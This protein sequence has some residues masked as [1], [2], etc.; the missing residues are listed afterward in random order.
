MIHKSDVY[1]F[2]VVMILCPSTQIDCV[3]KV[4]MSML[5]CCLINSFY[6]FEQQK[7]RILCRAKNDFFDGLTEKCHD[8]FSHKSEMGVNSP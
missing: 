1:L 5:Q 4:P 7:Q 2:G 6:F 3:I 8:T